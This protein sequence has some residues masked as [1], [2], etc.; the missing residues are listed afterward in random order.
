MNN[1]LLIVNFNTIDKNASKLFM[2][3]IIYYRSIFIR[4]NKQS[5]NFLKRYN[6]VRRLRAFLSGVFR[7][8]FRRKRWGGAYKMG[9]NVTFCREIRDVCCGFVTLFCGSY[10]TWWSAIGF[11]FFLNR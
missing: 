9:R 7:R 1:F 4:E 8:V 10:D 2:I 5:G 11:F 3:I 6:T